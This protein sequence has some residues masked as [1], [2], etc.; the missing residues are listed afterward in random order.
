LEDKQLEYGHVKSNILYRNISNQE[1]SLELKALGEEE[2]SEAIQFFEKQFEKF[3]TSFN[4][5]IEKVNSSE[6]KGSFLVKLQNTK[7]KL[8]THK[9][10][11]DYDI[12]EN[13]IIS[14]E[15]LIKETVLNNRARNTDIKNSLMLELDEALK[16]NDLFEVNLA[17][18]DIKE[19]WIKTGRASDETFETLEGSFKDK[20]QGFYDK[21]QSF[22]D[23]KAKLQVAKVKKYEV[24]IEQ[25][26]VII[27]NGHLKSEVDKVIALQAEWKNLGSIPEKDYKPLN[28]VYFKTCD[29]FF[30]LL[31]KQ[32]KAEN[33]LSKEDF[34][35]NLLVKK[36]LVE[37]LSLLDQK[38]L[39]E[40]VSTELNSLKSEWKNTGKVSKKESDIINNSFY[41]LNGSIMEKQFIFNL[42]KKK[43]NSFDSDD[44][45]KQSF[46]IKKL[47]KT[48]LDRDK[49]DLAI[50]KENMDNMHVNKG[51]FVDMLE[52]KLKQYV[53]KVE[54]KTKILESLK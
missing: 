45:D 31:K 44:A 16:N 40:N 50:F 17:I 9:G 12:I 2:E 25:I 46:L 34:N 38:S 21:R 43:F 4:E 6:N 37:K 35:K 39:K 18:K 5:L 52:D 28:K 13:E 32:R 27:A 1:N 54:Q 3:S 14:Q 22:Y 48:L 30:D 49:S 19:R 7:A 47:T 20:V 15:N 51:S 36:E 8:T 33:T 11:G 24:V 29:N 42:A 23:D 53:R 41:Q 10:L 26:N